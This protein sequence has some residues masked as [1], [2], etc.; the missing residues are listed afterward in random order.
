MN[1]PTIGIRREDINRWERRAPLTPREV[2]HLCRHEDLSFVVQPS[3]HRVFKAE[4]YTRAGA[5]VTEDLN[6][7]DIIFAVKEIPVERLLADKVYIFFPHVIKG[8]PANMPMLRR[9]MELGCSLIDYERVVDVKGRRLLFFGRYA[10]LAGMIDA[11]WALAQRLKIEGIDTPL[12]GLKPAYQYDSLAEAQG[13]GQ[14]VGE[15]IKREGVGAALAP[16]VVGITGYG[17]VSQGAQEALAVMPVEELAAEELAEFFERGEWSD[18]TLYKV[19]F[20]EEHI[21]EPVAPGDRFDLQEYYD[22]PEL[23]RSIF[24]RYLPY[25][26][27]LVN[28]VYWDDRYP[29]LVT[30]ALLRDLYTGNQPRLRIIGDI[31]CDLGG[32][33]EVTTKGTSPDAPVY[34][35]DLDKDEAVDGFAGRGPVIYSVYNLPAELPRDSS[36]YF[37]A[38]L[39]P[40]VREIA[41]ADWERG[42]ATCGLPDEI[43]GAVI[44]YRGELTPPYRYLERYL[45]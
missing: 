32:S 13:D 21:V 26:T 14:D 16:L 38:R 17:N 24:A 5:T 31:S 19:V 35:Y 36:A 33:V 39:L 18:R 2:E 15:R 41:R 45:K 25:L 42:Y 23:Y 4:E 43:R 8:Q 11:A 30:K 12:A 44:L 7:A 3:P 9:M 27:L 20:R 29:R 22:H 1:T 6:A 34:C 40:Y 10:G 28:A 37:S